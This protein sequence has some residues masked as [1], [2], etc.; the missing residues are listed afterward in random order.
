M[1]SLTSCHD[2]TA[3]IV[4]QHGPPTPRL[5]MRNDQQGDG[6]LR[7]QHYTRARQRRSHGHNDDGGREATEGGKRREEEG[8]TRDNSSGLVKTTTPGETTAPSGGSG[9][10]DRGLEEGRTEGT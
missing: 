4:K 5:K 8:M 1:T 9:E 3:A 10:G 6:L 7:L 2:A